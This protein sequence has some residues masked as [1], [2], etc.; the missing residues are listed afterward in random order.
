MLGMIRFAA[1][2]AL[3]RPAMEMSPF[4]PARELKNPIRSYFPF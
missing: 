1:Q 3:R 2:A 4:L